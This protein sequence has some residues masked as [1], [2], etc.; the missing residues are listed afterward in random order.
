MSCCDIKVISIPQCI[1]QIVMPVGLP[2]GTYTTVLTDKFENK[3]N[4]DFEVNGDNNLII[5]LS[6]YPAGLLTKYAGVFTF[7]IFSGCEKVTI[8]QCDT[9]YNAIA[10]KFV[11]T[12]Y[13]GVDGD[14]STYTICC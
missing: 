14:T 5:N 11:G 4:V 6:S 10:F 13:S 9:E 12:D 1:S 8:I 7:E 3:Y 2:E